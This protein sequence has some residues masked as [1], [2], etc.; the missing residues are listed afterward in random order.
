MEWNGRAILHV[1][2]DAFFTSVE[3]RDRPELRD[4]PVLVG[5]SGPRSVVAAASYEARKFGCRSA[6]PMSTAMRLCPQAIIVSGKHGRYSEVSDQVFAI[7][8]RASPLVQPVSIDEAYLDVTGS[9]RLL[10]D[11]P[12][13]AER[14]R[15]EIRAELGL[16]ASVGVAPN[17][18]VAKIASDLNKPDGLT[19][20]PPERVH[21]VLDPLPIERIPGVGP[22]AKR[23]LDRLG[24]RTIGD[25]RATPCETLVACLGS[26]G[27]E[28]ARKADGR[29]D[30]PVRVDREAKS[31]GRE[32]T[33]PEDLGDPE[34][35]RRVL[36]WH[37]EQVAR[38][39]RRAA[40]QA[41]GITVK[42][43]YGNFET[44]SRSSTLP[45]PTDSTDELYR[46]SRVLFDEW[47]SRSF[48]PVRLIGL[49]ATSLTREM[50]LMLFGSSE[51]S[52]GSGSPMAA[53]E[54]AAD[55]IVQ[56]FGKA[57]IRRGAT[58]DAPMRDGKRA[59]DRG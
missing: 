52:G 8:E 18:L 33:F 17:K 6:M 58:L 34:E 13:I 10:G 44:I 7:L 27:E 12:T 57:S 24:I 26:Y 37:A 53:A 20:V 39:L 35:V 25:V 49:T 21:A 2:M 50:Q 47:A 23:S 59:H 56:R 14:L 3:Q 15:R 9:I 32:E 41:S 55:A 22:S 51:G 43:R 48:R 4:K 29:D 16:T 19:V 54:R 40:V 5:G 36:L 28:I 11:P 1:D 38:R 46:G 42:I 31:I 45:E 30:R